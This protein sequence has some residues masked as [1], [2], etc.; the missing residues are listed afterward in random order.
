[1]AFRRVTLQG[2][3]NADFTGWRASSE[4][5]SNMLCFFFGRQRMRLGRFCTTTAKIIIPYPPGFVKAGF[6]RRAGDVMRNR[7]YRADKAGSR[8]K[9]QSPCRN[10]P[11]AVYS[12]GF[13]VPEVI[14]TPDLSL[15]SMAC[16]FVR[17]SS[18]NFL[19]HE[20]RACVMMYM[21]K[22]TQNTQNTALLRVFRGVQLANS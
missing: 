16:C 22:M 15:R 6:C 17:F 11:E 5:S 20:I 2:A 14:R 8:G 18:N 21:T 19:S 3:E 10:C 7:L 4:R 9:E 1:M 12:K 13:G